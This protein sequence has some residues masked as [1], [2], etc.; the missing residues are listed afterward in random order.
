MTISSQKTKDGVKKDP[1]R[2]RYYYLWYS[3]RGSNMLQ[4]IFEFKGDLQE[5]IT[6]GRKHCEVMHYRFSRV[7]PAIVDLDDQEMRKTTDNTYDEV[8]EEQIGR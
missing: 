4:K 6:R 8:F 7:R 5:A 1:L 2:V 3:V